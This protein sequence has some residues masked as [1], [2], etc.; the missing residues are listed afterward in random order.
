MKI[1]PCGKGK[2]YLQCCGR[3]IEGNELPN[4]PEEL[5]R[6]RYTAYTLA[7]MEYI[8]ATMKEPASNDFD[9]ASVKQWAQQV[10]WL[11]LEVI[12][13]TPVANNR[14]EVEFITD[15][16]L[17]NKYYQLHEASEFLF[18]EGRWYYIDGQLEANI[19]KVGRNESCPCGSQKKY[20]KCCGKEISS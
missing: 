12:N 15:Y 14:G 9:A 18:A 6:S 10:K 4:S 2:E 13:V 8:Q 5:M 16:C 3:Y 1:C 7:N 19:A 17:Q 11:K 20:K